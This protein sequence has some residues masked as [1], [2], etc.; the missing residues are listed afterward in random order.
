MPVCPISSRDPKWTT[1][2]VTGKKCGATFVDREFQNILSRKI[3]PENFRRLDGETPEIAIG[4]H[5]AWGPELS[6]LMKEFELE[7]RAFDG[8]ENWE[9]HFA[10]PRRLNHLNIPENGVEGGEVKF[11]G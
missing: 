1:D 8:G 4:S 5:I 10:L 11:T 6:E 3:G 7:K 2:E 9:K